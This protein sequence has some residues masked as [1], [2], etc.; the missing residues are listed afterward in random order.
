MVPPPLSTSFREKTLCF[1][2]INRH[3]IDMAVNFSHKVPKSIPKLP[4]REVYTSK[5]S[6]FQG[7]C[8]N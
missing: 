3:I 8:F 7:S 6:N 4:H 5:I 1:S 2:A